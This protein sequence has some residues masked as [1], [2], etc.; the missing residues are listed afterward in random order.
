MLFSYLSYNY[1]FNNRNNTSYHSMC[2]LNINSGKTYITFNCYY[3]YYVTIL[4]ILWI[5]KLSPVYLIWCQTAINLQ[6]QLLNPDRSAPGTMLYHITLFHHNDLYINWLCE[7]KYMQLYW[8]L[9]P[10]IVNSVLII[11]NLKYITLTWYSYE[12]NQSKLT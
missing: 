2:F 1:I 5:G 3:G 9:Y 11:F 6:S 10:T 8:F 12:K 7:E 4:R